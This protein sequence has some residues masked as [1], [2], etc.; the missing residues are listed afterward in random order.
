MPPGENRAQSRWIRVFGLI[1][2]AA[3]VLCPSP[4]QAHV[5]WFSD[6][7]YGDA[8]NEF[9]DILSPTFY[10]LGLLSMAVI[11]VLVIVE[12]RIH[13]WAP[14]RRLEI[15]LSRQA[16]HAQS[17]MRLGMA[18][19]LLW[20]WQAGTIFAP[21]LTTES[22]TVLWLELL[23]A[24]FLIF[25]KT[26][27]LAA[28]GILGLYGYAIWENGIFYMLDYAMFAGIAWYFFASSTS[29]EAIQRTALPVVYATVG[30]CLIWLGIEKLVYPSWA[31]FLLEQHP[32]LALGFEHDFFVMAA[33]FVEISLGFMIMACLQQRL[34]ALFITFLFFLT[35]MVFGRQ[36]VV[37]HTMIHAVL[38]VFLLAGAGKAVP[39][40]EWLPRRVLHAP[41]AA[42]GFVVFL[43][44]LMVPYVEG[45]KLMHQTMAFR[46]ETADP[47][48]L[49]HDEMHKLLL[50]VGDST[51][52]I[53]EVA[54]ALHKDPVAGWN[55][56]LVTENFEFTPRSA[57]LT[58]QPG[59]GHAHLHI[60]GKKAARI[61]SP[62]FHIDNLP[63]GEYLIEVTLNAY[64]HATLAVDGRPV[65]AVAEIV[66]VAEPRES[67]C[68]EP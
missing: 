25:R 34:L 66:V 37:G 14:F 33:A 40:L 48:E 39:P 65:R 42:I 41:A 3:A 68:G 63:P 44:L 55:L 51:A 50:E 15:W 54:I 62:W 29:R 2:V 61:Y 56:E 52:G 10:W 36:E 16:K 53:P 46:A 57:G 1:A 19:T 59:Q 58:N 38:I 64:N 9:S 43:G 20:S 7:S 17:I 26:I 35:T 4:A 11:A 5:K 23:T 47:T 32:V 28:A 24:V 27:P 31:K 12:Q 13:R 18:A 45:S 49:S 21:D 8:P 30:F 67:M 22:E 60:D 6:F